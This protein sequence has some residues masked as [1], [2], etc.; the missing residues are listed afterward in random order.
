MKRITIAALAA[1]IFILAGCNTTVPDERI[2]RDGNYTIGMNFKQIKKAYVKAFYEGKLGYQHI[3]FQWLED[4]HERI[5]PFTD[6]EKWRVKIDKQYEKDM[7]IVEK[8]TQKLDTM[9]CWQMREAIKKLYPIWYRS[10]AG[11]IAKLRSQIAQK[12][13][14][15]KCKVD[16]WKKIP[17]HPKND[18]EWRVDF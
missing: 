2:D 14:E 8:I 5:N 10:N 12:M 9:K 1:M 16:G 17:V 4:N 3:Y 13:N 7:K 6:L 11:K 18:I 15:K